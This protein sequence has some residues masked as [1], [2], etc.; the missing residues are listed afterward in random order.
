M[1]KFLLSWWLASHGEYK[2]LKGS[3]TFGER[4]IDSAVNR[5]TLI[6]EATPV[7]YGVSTVCTFQLISQACWEQL[8]PTRGHDDSA[9]NLTLSYTQLTGWPR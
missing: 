2:H 9:G 3:V 5:H 1:H 6:G 8:G 7:A 4:R